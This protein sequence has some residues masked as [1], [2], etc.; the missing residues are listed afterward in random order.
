[1]AFRQTPRHVRFLAATL[2]AIVAQ[3]AAGTPQETFRDTHAPPPPTSVSDFTEDQLV[4]IAEMIGRTLSA[5]DNSS[6][7]SD[8]KVYAA[9]YE[10]YLQTGKLPPGNDDDATHQRSSA[11]PIVGKVRCSEV[12][13]DNPHKGANALHQQVVK[14]KAFAHCATIFWNVRPPSH[15][16]RWQLVMN[17]RD[18][19]GSRGQVGSAVWPKTGYSAAWYRN[20]G[21][22][23]GD[24]G[25]QVFARDCQNGT[26]N[27]Q[28]SIFLTLPYPFYFDGPNPVGIDDRT[29][30]VTN[31]RPPVASSDPSTAQ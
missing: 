7:D 18:V 11:D 31:C 20:S 17:L 10:Q 4:R 27:N 15:Q 24:V 2:T 16:V 3:F 8:V 25:T 14:A 6:Y 22:D 12:K 19:A 21:N 5:T 1:M 13:A 9:A 30:S 23:P 26:Y 29:A 28:V